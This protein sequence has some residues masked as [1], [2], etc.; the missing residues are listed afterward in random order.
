MTVLGQSE[1]VLTI[2]GALAQEES[3][4]TSVFGKEFLLGLQTVELV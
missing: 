4:N 3:A 2:F 1:F